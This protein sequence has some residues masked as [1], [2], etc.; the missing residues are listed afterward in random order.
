MGAPADIY[1]RIGVLHLDRVLSPLLGK[2]PLYISEMW[3]LYFLLWVV[4]AHFCG[5]AVI[6]LIVMCPAFMRPFA[7]SYHLLDNRVL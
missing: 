1:R 6:A 4:C 3:H 2:G 7:E 5:A